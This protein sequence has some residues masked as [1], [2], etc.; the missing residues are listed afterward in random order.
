MRTH[1]MNI[2]TFIYR[3]QKKIINKL[4]I[5][6][7]WCSSLLLFYLFTANHQTTHNF[8]SRCVFSLSHTWC[9]IFVY[10]FQLI[11]TSNSNALIRFC[12]YQNIME[13]KMRRKLSS[14]FLTKWEWE[15]ETAW[16][17]KK[18]YGYGRTSNIPETWKK[19][20]KT[21]IFSLTVLSYSNSSCCC[22]PSVC[23]YVYVRVFFFHEEPLHILFF[24]DDFRWHFFQHVY[25]HMVAHWIL[26]TVLFEQYTHIQVMKDERM[27]MGRN[28]KERYKW[29]WFCTKKKLPCC[30]C[31]YILG[32]W[33][34]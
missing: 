23:M 2:H 9:H 30:C 5:V 16:Y 24:I 22:F 8:N 12:S 14:F 10:D 26:F 32:S 13:H 28:K 20:L 3:K 31:A 34:L 6:S 21:Q 11:P 19:Y 4:D 15:N 7:I 17:L 27:R 29:F 1:Q 33:E 25:E 18:K